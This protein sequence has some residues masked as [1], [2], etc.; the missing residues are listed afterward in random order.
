MEICV[1]FFYISSQLTSL[2]S[3]LGVPHPT[4]W[5][6]P[7]H[8]HPPTHAHPRET[9]PSLTTN[10]SLWKMTC[11]RW[12]HSFFIV[13]CTTSF[14]YRHLKSAST[15]SHLNHT[16]DTWILGLYQLQKLMHAL[17]FAKQEQKVW[18]PFRVDWLN[19]CRWGVNTVLRRI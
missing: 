1:H 15:N 13:P 14:L 18:S 9:L 3:L 16:Q 4:P 2:T 8:P 6:P 19:W 12:N 11:T 10:W 7:P 5:G 17:G